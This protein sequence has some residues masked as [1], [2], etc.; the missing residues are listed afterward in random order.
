MPNIAHYISVDENVASPRTGASEAMHGPVTN[1]NPK[2]LSPIADAL[3]TQLREALHG[4]WPEHSD[5]V[6]DISRYALLAPGKMLRPLLLAAAA[7]AVG[8]DVE[9]VVPAALAI[10]YLHVGS[11]VHDDVIDGD[12]TR[13]GQPSVPH[14]YGMPNAIA[15]GDALMMRAFSA[16]AACAE[17]GV[18]TAAA[19]A[20][21]RA[22][23]DA[24][25]DMCRGQALESTMVSAPSTPLADYLAVMTLK[26]AA[27][28]RGACQAGAA[29]GG[30]EST[31]L[32][33]AGR[34]GEHLGLAF[35]MHDDLL[36]YLSDPAITGKSGLSD[37]RNLRPTYPVL[38]AHE[39]GTAQQR[40]QLVTALSGQPPPERAFT[41]L[42]NTLNET[43]ALAHAV[44]RAEAEAAM[45]KTSLADLPFYDHTAILA[46]VADMSVDRSR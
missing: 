25:V 7:G 1:R 38:L 28:F 15:A 31:V 21:M 24:G 29:L 10:E 23:S 27:L 3:V 8:G 43:G 30:A 19:L 40:A 22:I 13:R 46:E 14:R 41:A 45:A 34:Y 12:A 16:V 9:Q 11:L 39:T 20:A 2:N 4:E 18:S 36:P 17:R 33:A 6:L 42:R 44:E 37:V 32:D 35:Q 26:T 5:P